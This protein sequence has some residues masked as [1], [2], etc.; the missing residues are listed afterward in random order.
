MTSNIDLIMRHI[1]YFYN[2]LS[3]RHSARKPNQNVLPKKWRRMYLLTTP[4]IWYYE[5]CY[6]LNLDALRLYK[7][8]RSSSFYEKTP[9]KSCKADVVFP[10]CYCKE[11][12][13]H[14]RH[15]GM[16]S[17]CF[18]SYVSNQPGCTE[19]KLVWECDQCQCK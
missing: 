13:R 11:R 12:S 2:Q 10:P 17:A 19:S 5:E 3:V 4:S 7:E 18:C 8:D 14:R 6:L 9:L 15:R 1:R 16:T